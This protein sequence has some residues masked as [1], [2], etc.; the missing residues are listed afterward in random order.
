MRKS[1]RLMSVLAGLSALSFQANADMYIIGNVEASNYSFS[2]SVGVTMEETST[3]VYEATT[4]IQGSPDAMTMGWFAFVDEL[5]EDWNYV[6]QHRYGPSTPDYKLTSG[7]VFTDIVYGQDRS[8]SIEG[9]E[10]HIVFDSAN[11]TV[12]ATSTTGIVLPTTM[13]IVGDVDDCTWTPTQGV[14]MT[15]ESDGVFTVTATIN[16]GEG[17]G[18]SSFGYVGFVSE[19]STD[20]N[21][22]DTFN[23]GRYGAGSYNYAPVPGAEV[24]LNRTEYS[25]G[26]VGGEYD[27]TVD[28]NRNVVAFT[29]TGEIAYNFP[30]VI[31]LIGCVDGSN[32]WNTT[33]GLAVEESTTAPGEYEAAITVYEDGWFGFAA[34]LG[35]LNDDGTPDWYNFNPSRYIPTDNAELVLGEEAGFRMSGDGS[36]FIE[37]GEYNCKIKLTSITSGTITLTSNLSTGIDEVGA[38]VEARPVAT[39]GGITI[40]GNVG[41][42]NVYTTGGALVASGMETVECPAG[43]YVVTV[44]GKAYK[45]IVK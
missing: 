31:Y 10:Y 36:F 4:K 13:Y 37:P 1:L 35:G 17:A 44:D 19:L 16:G 33:S 6:N 32:G 24:A 9:G 11:M 14:A 3:G 8:F 5:S 22:W 20:E 25:F 15:Q 7:E 29:P 26:V 34:A 30:D 28:L 41:C 43:V 39:D 12:T 40:S 45:V 21:D 18:I 23:A 2:P 42:M 38:E 27:I